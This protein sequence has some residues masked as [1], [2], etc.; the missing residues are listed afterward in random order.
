MFG[1]GCFEGLETLTSQDRRVQD[2]A[3][4]MT[5]NLNTQ[6]SLQSG[7]ECARHMLQRNVGL[8]RHLIPFEEA[9]K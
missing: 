1:R 8:L 7:F 4:S 6:K 9:F 5:L 3:E 2:G